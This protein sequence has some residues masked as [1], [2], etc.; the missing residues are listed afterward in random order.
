MVLRLALAPP[1]SSVLLPGA[2][3]KAEKA[4]KAELKGAK[5]AEERYVVE[6]GA[7][8][9]NLHATAIGSHGHRDCASILAVEQ[10]QCDLLNARSLAGAAV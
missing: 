3:K 9:G 10:A 5:N 2:A 7:L 4:K 6:A 8:H 1:R